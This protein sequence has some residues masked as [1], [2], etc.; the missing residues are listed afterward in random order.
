MK[1]KWNAAPSLNK[2][3]I[4]WNMYLSGGFSF[5]FFWYRLP[6]ML[7]LVMA[8]RGNQRIYLRFYLHVFS[9]AT[10]C[11]L[12]KW[13]MGA[14]IQHFNVC[15]INSSDRIYSFKCRTE[16]TVQHLPT[17]FAFISFATRSDMGGAFFVPR[18]L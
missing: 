7:G 5:F 9:A 13:R 16:F 11:F 14:G 15:S 12:F 17:H 8:T 18:R 4:L 6:Q 10:S 1:N 3:S 2:L